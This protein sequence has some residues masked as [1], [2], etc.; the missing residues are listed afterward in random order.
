ME[1]TPE[2]KRAIEDQF[3]RSMI[4]FA[5]LKIGMFVLIRAIAKALDPNR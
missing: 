1:F 4:A 2:E 3:I 5:A